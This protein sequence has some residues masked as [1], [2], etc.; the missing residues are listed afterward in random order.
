VTRIGDQPIR[1]AGELSQRIGAARP[2]ERLKLQVWRNRAAIEL[3]VELQSAT[4]ADASQSAP[5]A[6]PRGQR[7]PG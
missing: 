2:G 5:R 1:T 4:Q 3:A 6:V 7:Q